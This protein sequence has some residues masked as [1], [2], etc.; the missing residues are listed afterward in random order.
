MKWRKSKSRRF[1]PYWL[2]A[3]NLISSRS[4]LEFWIQCSIHYEF[5]CQVTNSLTY[6]TNFT[7]KSWVVDSQISIGNCGGCDVI[8]TWGFWLFNKW[9]LKHLNTLYS[10]QHRWLE[11]PTRSSWIQHLGPE[12]RAFGCASWHKKLVSAAVISRSANGRH[13]LPR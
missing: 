8:R 11:H 12:D 2:W 9:R 5:F 7:S 10:P 13:K 1:H 4:L 6:F 3:F